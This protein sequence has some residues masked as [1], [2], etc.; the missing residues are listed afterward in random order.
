MNNLIIPENAIELEPDSEVPKG[1][2]FARQF[3][4][5]FRQDLD[6]A[7]TE[8]L[9]SFSIERAR[10]DEFL[11]E[12]GHLGDVLIHPIIGPARLPLKLNPDESLEWQVLRTLSN[13]IRKQMNR[14]SEFGIH[15]DPPFRLDAEKGSISLTVRLTEEL[16]LKSHVMMVKNLQVTCKSK[17]KHVQ[18]HIDQWMDDLENLPLVLQMEVKN[19][20]KDTA[21]LM[22]RIL[23]EF[24]D[25]E[26]NFADTYDSIKDFRDRAMAEDRLALLPP[27]SDEDEE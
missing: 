9:S 16:L 22:K 4:R 8:G 26:E 11:M 27:D 20:D 15:G 10:F 24:T 5:E 18:K 3:V 23:R 17:Q 6:D 14:V 2:A 13:S 21:Q 12:K 25:I 7:K 1:V 19:L